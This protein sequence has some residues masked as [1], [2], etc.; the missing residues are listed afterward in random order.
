MNKK[1][2]NI[3]VM[4]NETAVVL[5]YD[6]FMHIAESYDYFASEEVDLDVAQWYRDIADSI[7]YQSGLNHFEN[8][9]NDDEW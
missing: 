7:R 8:E 2:L 5:N 1:K 9:S 3:K 4:Q 6:V